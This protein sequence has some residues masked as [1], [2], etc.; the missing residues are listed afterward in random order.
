MSILVKLGNLG[1]SF[2]DGLRVFDFLG[3]VA[4][5]LYLAPVFWVAGM[6]KLAAFDSTVEWFGN[7]DWGLGLPY[8][9]IMAGLATGTELAGAVCLLLGFAVRWISIPLMVTMAIAILKVHW[10]N[11]WQA[12]ADIQSPW[13]SSTLGQFAWEDMSGAGERLAAARDI[14]KEHGNYDWLTETG[15]FV[16]SNN[17]VEW[18][19]TYF[20]MLLV[21]FFI[22]AGRF[23]SL[24]YYLYLIFRKNRKNK[25]RKKPADDVDYQDPLAEE[26]SLHEPIPGDK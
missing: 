19:V 8:P 22:G 14:L 9:E 13:A 15:N 17:G 21:L 20:I 1:T 2:F 12:V 16:I 24:D 10:A 4:L 5:R 11:G 23:F 25:K 3:P 6:N 26:M 18:A 7:A